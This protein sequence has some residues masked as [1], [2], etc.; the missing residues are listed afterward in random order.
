MV[1]ASFPDESVEQ[2]VIDVAPLERYLAGLESAPY[3]AQDPLRAGRMKPFSVADISIMGETGC[4]VYV[5]LGGER[6]DSVAS[7]IQNSYIAKTLF[8]GLLLSVG[9]TGLVGLFLFSLLTKRLRTM[10]G[11]VQAFEKGEL[12]KRIP[13]Q[14]DDE[15]GRLSTSFNQM[16]DTIVA[17]M[18]ELKRTDQL[19]RELIANVSHDL[20]SPL[21]SIQGYLE[22]INI[23]DA[24]LK[25]G[26]RKRYMDIALR[27]TRTLSTLV[28]EL[29]ELSKLDA[30]QIQPELE[31]FSL[32]ELVQD[33]VMQFQPQAESAGVTLEAVMPERLSLVYAD[34]ALVER[35][36]CNL[37]D[38]AVRHTPTKGTVRIVPTN[39][40][41][42]VGVRIIDT[43]IGIAPEDLPHIFDR[44]YRVEKSRQRGKSGGAGLGLAI[45][46]KIVELH[47]ST[48]SVQSV[49]N[50][51]TT[52]MFALP[53]PGSAHSMQLA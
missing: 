24:T 9:L 42:G 30:Q 53:T 3:L 7:A 49:L 18:D 12:K 51:G 10:Q 52:F 25:P 29:F 28:G 27:N 17:N 26:D 46:K 43:G 41:D 22:T 15:I 45:A 19:R 47:G 4:F 31:S 50:K 33:V 13:S 20:R 36:I 16:A 21:A 1:K 37:I 48:L 6:Y 11:T 35:A 14:S 38:N 23:K 40:A 32:A 39:E 34:I 44:F 8:Y 5:I 2:S